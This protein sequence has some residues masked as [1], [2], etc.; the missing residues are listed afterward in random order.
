MIASTDRWMPV[1]D[2]SPAGTSV[3][4]RARTA[5]PRGE[6]PQPIARRSI[7]MRFPFV[8]QHRRSSLSWLGAALLVGSIATFGVAAPAHAADEPQPDPA[9]IATGDR[10][11]VM[12]A[13]GNAFVVA[14]PP[15]ASDPQKTK[16]FEDFK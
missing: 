14:E 1:S 3:A 5:V 15:D 12:D 16:D 9:G 11:S 10:T 6:P 7:D 13:G 2:E 4:L 8:T